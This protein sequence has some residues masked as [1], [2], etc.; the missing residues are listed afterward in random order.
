MIQ[1]RSY[2]II[3]LFIILSFA[4]IAL[5]PQ[6]SVQLNPGKSAGSIV[7]SFSMP[8][9]SPEVLEQQIT[10]KI[11]AGLNTL[12]GIKKV[13]SNS[14]YNYGYVTLE[15]EKRTDLDQLRFE[16]AMLIRQ[17]YPK[18][19]QRSQLPYYSTKLP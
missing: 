11:E 12:Q 4:G 17:I 14:L 19:T 5:L 3:L 7:V 8:N 16:V 1:R 9:A 13:T 6:L 18:A 15:L 2:Q 10:S